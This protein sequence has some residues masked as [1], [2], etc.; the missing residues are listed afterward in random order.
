MRERLR[1][2]VFGQVQGVFFRHTAKTTADRL[3]IVGFVRNE[4]DGSVLV[5]AEGEPAAMAEFVAYCREG[6]EFSKVLRAE[7][8][9]VPLVNGK[10]FDIL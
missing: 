10:S 1:I 9:G 7:I 5:E 6:T 2:T 8:E 4:P 3:G